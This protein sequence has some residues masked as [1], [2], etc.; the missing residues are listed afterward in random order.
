MVTFI[1]NPDGGVTV[2]PALT[3]PTLYLDY[4]VIADIAGTQI[5]E[6]VREKI[7]EGGTLYLSWAH[8]IELFSLGLGPTFDKLSTYITSFGAHFIIIDADANAVIKREREWTPQRQNPAI[9][10]DWLA[11]TMAKWAQRDDEEVSLGIL[12][13][14]MVGEPELIQH[15]KTLHKRHKENVKKMFDVER[16][17]YR[18]DKVVRKQLDTIEYPYRRP[19]V[20]S[21]VNLELTRECVRTNEQFNPS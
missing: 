18:T 12:L 20:T 8:F 13:D 1:R 7:C 6:R 4:G 19:F 17:R 21:K 15:I 14:Y 10:G 11:L 2:I 3:S 16:D 5:G 9:D